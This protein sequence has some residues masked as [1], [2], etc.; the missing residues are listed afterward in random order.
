M[1]T[2]DQLEVTDLKFLRAIYFHQDVFCYNPIQIH[3]YAEFWPQGLKGQQASRQNQ[4]KPHIS[5]TIAPETKSSTLSPSITH[6]N[7]ASL[8]PTTDRILICVGKK[9]TSILPD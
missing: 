3:L 4:R 7:M 8:S 5:D 1:D 6:L 2:N 9:V